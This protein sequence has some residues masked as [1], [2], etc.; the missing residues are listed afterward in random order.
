M[1]L[2]D[3]SVIFIYVSGYRQE[4]TAFLFQVNLLQLRSP[5]LTWRLL[6]AK[7]AES[8]AF[9]AVEFQFFDDCVIWFIIQI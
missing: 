7:G 2:T 6:T 3:M 1:L 4:V 9:V 5:G 8:E